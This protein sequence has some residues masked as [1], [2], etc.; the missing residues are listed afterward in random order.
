MSSRGRW[1]AAIAG[2]VVALNLVLVGLD[3]LTRGPQGPESSS[4]ATASRGL[5]AYSDLLSR[6]GRRVRRLRDTLTDRSLTRAG[7]LV[8]LDPQSLLPSEA[9]ALRRFLDGGGRVIAGGSP[10]GAWLREALGHR[11]PRWQ[12]GDGT[13]ARVLAPSA[14]TAG[15]RRILSA[16][17]GRWSKAR[18]ALP[19]LGR[20]G[21]D[22]LALV[23]PLRRGRL[24]LLAD[25]S[26]L[27]N[28]LLAA[29]DNAAF[30]LALAPRGQVTFAEAAHGY[31]QRRGVAAIPRRWKLALAGLILAAL[32][33]ILARARRLGPAQLP[34]RR[35]APPRR[36]YVD[37]MAL[38]L[39]RTRAPEEATRP[40][41]RA[42]RERLIVRARLPEDAPAEAW[43]AAGA[44]AGLSEEEVSALL[45]GATGEDLVLARGRA[46]ATLSRGGT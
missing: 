8:L 41:A 16:G 39:K 6:S 4:Y 20:D 24:I 40:V 10:P 21:T 46:L 7:T 28:R 33:F 15:V 44:A 31:G 12:P 13:G 30:G 18:S 42:A 25:A 34:A 19:I 2:A 38:A 23:T 3:R 29:A 17:Q 9:R 5:A 22:A 37:A 43:G 45:D 1:I 27:Q 26:P 14:E 35:L 32:V 36:D 11:A